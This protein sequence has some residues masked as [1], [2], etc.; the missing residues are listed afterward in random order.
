MTLPPFLP[1]RVLGPSHSKAF[2]PMLPARPFFFLAGNKTLRASH[3]KGPSTLAGKK[4]GRPP[5]FANPTL[6]SEFNF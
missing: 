4:G 2:S 5:Y 1:A 6:L 3:S